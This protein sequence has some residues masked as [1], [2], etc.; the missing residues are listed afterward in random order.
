MGLINDC[1]R[2]FDNYVGYNYI[3]ELD[4]CYSL[5]VAFKGEQ[6][7][8]LIGLHYLEDIPE[9]DT[10]IVTNPAKRVYKKICKNQITQEVIEKSKQYYK[11]K[12]RIEKF[13][14]FDDVINC[15]IIIDFDYTKVPQT[16]IRSK[17]ILYTEC[18]GF[19]IM[20]GLR[21]AD[22]ILIPETFIV[23]NTDYYIKNQIHYEVINISR[24]S[25]AADKKH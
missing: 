7:P 18:D 1:A 25:L 14:K 23:D 24:E 9:V 16:K 4:C 6:F 20:L 5:K 8:H 17:Y 12:D 11:I 21:Y 3:L 22:D 2:L 19:Y 15:K 13:L 10:R